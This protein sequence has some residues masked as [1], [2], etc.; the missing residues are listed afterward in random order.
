MLGFNFMNKPDLTLL[1]S[2]PPEKYFPKI[3][4]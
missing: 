1:L 3:A 2:A 4:A